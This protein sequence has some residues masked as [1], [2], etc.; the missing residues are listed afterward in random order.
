MEALQVLR[1]LGSDNFL[2]FKLKESTRTSAKKLNSLL[3]KAVSLQGFLLPGISLITPT[4]NYE[5]KQR[6]SFISLIITS[7]NLSTAR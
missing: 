2:L 6:G 7:F 1:K 5:W 4:K 3:R